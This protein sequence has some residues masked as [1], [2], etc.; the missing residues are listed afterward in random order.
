MIKDH[1]KMH[2][3]EKKNNA[4]N[5]KR[6]R[7]NKKKKKLHILRFITN[8]KPGIKS[9][10]IIIFGPIKSSTKRMDFLNFLIFTFRF[11]IILSRNN[12]GGRL[13]FNNKWRLDYCTRLDFPLR[14]MR[15]NISVY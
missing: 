1:S 2:E 11:T 3:K 13:K 5:K 14:I 7:Y 15:S 6:K 8:Q 12:S 4:R 9:F 10:L